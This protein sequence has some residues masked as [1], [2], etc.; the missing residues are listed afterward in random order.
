MCGERPAYKRSGSIAS[1]SNVLQL[2]EAGLSAYPLNDS[3]IA[4]SHPLQPR[5]YRRRPRYRTGLFLSHRR[6][7]FL[8]EEREE[9][10]ATTVSTVSNPII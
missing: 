6:R 1:G 2:T 8:M 5:E 10:Q 9:G 3:S 7:M 4:A